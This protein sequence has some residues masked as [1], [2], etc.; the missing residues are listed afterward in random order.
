VYVICDCV[1]PLRGGVQTLKF[2]L[3]NYYL[4]ASLGSVV[5][6]VA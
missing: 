5:S 6:N 4:V 3:R 2:T 1:E